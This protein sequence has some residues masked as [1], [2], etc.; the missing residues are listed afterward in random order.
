MDW[1]YYVVVM[2]AST[3]FGYILG[4]M[5][6]TAAAQA[7]QADAQMRAWQRHDDMCERC[8]KLDEESADAEEWERT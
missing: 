1:L 4:A 5:L 3:A 2:C 7:R 8:R 6:T